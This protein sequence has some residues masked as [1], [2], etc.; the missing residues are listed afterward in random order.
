MGPSSLGASRAASI[1]RGRRDV[2]W[3]G[4]RVTTARAPR[5]SGDGFVR[6]SDGHV[7]WGR[8]GAAGVVFV[9]RDG[10]APVVLL[11]LRSAMAHEG[12]TWS[13]PG[14]AIDE[15]ESPL[16]A[17]LREASEEVGE[18]PEPWR[19]LG[20]HVFEPATD[21][22]YTTAVIEV[23]HR[24]GSSR[25]FESDDVRWST[26]DEVDHLPL[27]AGFAAAWPHLRPIAEAG[28]RAG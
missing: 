3:Q 26:L 22:R 11:Q 25:N 24:F 20:E 5:R 1:A 15:G 14:G 4:D 9:V 13:C 23:P 6:C 12:G 17:A 21:W 18:A 27:H 8:F 7:R 10:G 19:L 28:D 16:E 2:A